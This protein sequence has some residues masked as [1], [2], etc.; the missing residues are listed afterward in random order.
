MVEKIL[1]VITR[2]SVDR[3]ILLSQGEKI[4][5]ELYFLGSRVC[6]PLFEPYKVERPILSSYECFV[7][8][9][10]L[11]KGQ[12]GMTRDVV[13]ETNITGSSLVSFMAR[14][15]G[16][17]LIEVELREQIEGALR[18]SLE[19]REKWDESTI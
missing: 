12:Q 8:I 4:T 2:T 13:Y 7:R 3:M 15:D 6:F 14:E 10:K 11:V 1:D 5:G 9:S 19:R 17:Y 18:V 16:E